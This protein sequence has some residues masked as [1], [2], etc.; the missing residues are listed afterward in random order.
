MT[1]ASTALPFR[2]TTQAPQAACGAQPFFA[3]TM[4]AVFPQVGQERHLAVAV[5]LLAFTI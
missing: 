5:E 1:Q 3:E 2:S 4:P